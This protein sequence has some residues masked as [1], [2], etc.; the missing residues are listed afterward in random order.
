VR[1]D[2]GI[3]WVLLQFAKA[4][5]TVVATFNGEAKIVAKPRIIIAA[6]KIAI[7]IV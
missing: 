5:S 7:I 2:P 1:F 6:I 3:P 4:C